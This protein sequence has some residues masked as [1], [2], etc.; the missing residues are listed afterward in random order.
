MI[1]SS[2]VELELFKTAAS[3]LVL[4]AGWFVGQRIIVGWDI[5]KKRQ[6]LDIAAAERFQSLYGELKEVSRTWRSAKKGDE[7]SPQPPKD[8]QWSLLLQSTK[9]ESQFESI[10]IKLATERALSETEI[11]AIGLFRQTCQHIRES[12]QKNELTESSAFGAA[13]LLLNDLAAEVTCIIGSTRQ[14]DVLDPAR[15]KTN[16]ERIASVRSADW[17]EA[18]LT[19]EKKLPGATVSSVRDV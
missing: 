15:A 14:R 6:E 13:Y 3:L 2:D 16:L 1:D 8:L 18:V 11:R 19:A 9:A 17:R 4:A 10:V 7:N 12:I 5:R